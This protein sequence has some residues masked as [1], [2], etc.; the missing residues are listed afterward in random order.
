MWSW[1]RHP[2]LSAFAF[3]PRCL[4]QLR[5]LAAPTPLLRLCFCGQ[6]DW[7]GNAHV[8]QSLERLRPRQVS[9]MRVAERISLQL[10]TLRGELS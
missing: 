3:S 5:G 9:P 6:G 1:G 7:F 8:A 10:L 4:P 2:V